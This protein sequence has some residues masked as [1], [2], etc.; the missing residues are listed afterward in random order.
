MFGHNK[1]EGRKFFNDHVESHGHLLVTSVFTTL[2]GEGPLAGMPAVFVRLAK[3][4]LA[5]SFCDTYFD[6]GDWMNAA[7]LLQ[8]ICDS[9]NQTIAALNE[10]PVLKRFALIITGGEPTLQPAL[11]S[12]MLIFSDAFKNIQ[13]ESNGLLYSEL[14]EQVIL[15]VSPKCS[16]HLAQKPGRYLKP[17]KQVLERANCLKFVI[18]SDPKSA[19]YQIPSWAADWQRETKRDIY[20][21]PMNEYN[22]TPAK[23]GELYEKRGQASFEE[24]STI[25]ERISFWEPGLLNLE[26]CRRNHEYAAEYCIKHGFRLTLQMQLFA[27]LP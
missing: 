22:R 11:G 15:V 5:C 13:I 21:S 19:Y 8:K 23:A 9:C 17:N 4:N 27:S 20:I 1:I 6:H 7:D 2:Q 10:F 26:C 18:S 14:P 12:M 24:R 16:D 25:G 3:C